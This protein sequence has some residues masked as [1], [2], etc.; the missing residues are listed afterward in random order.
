MK[1]RS[2]ALACKRFRSPHTGDQIASLLDDIHTSFDLDSEKLVATIT[3]NAANFAKAF[4]VY[5]IEPDATEGKKVKLKTKI[6]DLKL[7]LF[8]IFFVIN[9]EF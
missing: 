5:G 2:A 8:S 6:S 1:R 4:R 9:F 3:D 7:I